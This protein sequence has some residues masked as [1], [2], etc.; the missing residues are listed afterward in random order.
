VSKNIIVCLK[1]Y[2]WGTAVRERDRYFASPP[3]GARGG[4]QRRF[5]RLNAHHGVSGSAKT[6]RASVI[7]ASVGYTADAERR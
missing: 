3:G 6:F 5:D 4:E 7:I 2:Q 1:P